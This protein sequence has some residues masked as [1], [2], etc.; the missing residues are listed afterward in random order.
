MC[1]PGWRRF[2]KPYR[3]RM[4]RGGVAGTCFAAARKHTQ[5]RR[6]LR[7]ILQV[8]IDGLGS[9]D[10]LRLATVRLTSWPLFIVHG[11]VS[12]E[13]YTFACC[14]EI[15]SQHCAVRVRILST[16]NPDICFDYTATAL[17]ACRGLFD[18]RH[19]SEEIC[20]YKRRA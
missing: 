1:L 19:Q 2:C 13:P 9:T 17:Q 16:Q 3:S 11:S 5:Q 18:E 14:L 4:R 8:A 7:G 12:R 15:L 6:M 10:D 20:V